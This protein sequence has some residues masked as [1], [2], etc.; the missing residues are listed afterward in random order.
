MGV[1]PRKPGFPTTHPQENKKPFAT[2][3][4][5]V[6]QPFS[7][8]A[9]DEDNEVAPGSGKVACKGQGRACVKKESCV[10][11]V[12]SKDARVTQIKENV[13]FYTTIYR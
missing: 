10:N 3:R 11:G 4:P 7:I 9:N 8:E 13:S 12:V 1:Q 2:T 6:P 5:G